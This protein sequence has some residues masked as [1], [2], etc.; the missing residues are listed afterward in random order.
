MAEKRCYMV[1]Y[2]IVDNKVRN[3][4][5]NTLKDYG[6]RVQ[7]SVFECLIGPEAFASMTSKLENLINPAED[8]ILICPLCK[9]CAGLK[10]GL[11]LICSHE[12]KE[13]RVL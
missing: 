13:F 2:D 11:G 5:S 6:V 12:E 7:K 8:S 3:K 10:T 9:T 1:A 4:V